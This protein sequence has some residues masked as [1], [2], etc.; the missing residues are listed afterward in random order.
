VCIRRHGHGMRIWAGRLERTALNSA[1]VG[2]EGGQRSIFG[3]DVHQVERRIRPVEVTT[4]TGAFDQVSM[5]RA[6]QMTIF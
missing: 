4:A 2:A 3:G 5:K 1:A 6:T